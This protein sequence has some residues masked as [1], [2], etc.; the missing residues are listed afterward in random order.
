MRAHWDKA[1]KPLDT[2][3]SS[4]YAVSFFSLPRHYQFMDQLS[5]MAPDRK[6]SARRRFEIIPERV[7]EYLET[8]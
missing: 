2:P 7:Q 6:Y 4:P 8:G 5:K 3:V 1:V